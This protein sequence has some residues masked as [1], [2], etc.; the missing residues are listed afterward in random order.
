M[1]VRRHVLIDVSFLLMKLDLT[2]K[3]AWLIE[4]ALMYQYR[5]RKSKK[6][7]KKTGLLLDKIQVKLLGEE[8]GD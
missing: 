5:F 4:M 6:V 1:R 3:E 2:I 7:K 8:V